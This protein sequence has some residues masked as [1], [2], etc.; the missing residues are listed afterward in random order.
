MFESIQTLPDVY[1]RKATLTLTGFCIKSGPF[2]KCYDQGTIWCQ[3]KIRDAAPSFPRSFL[4]SISFSTHI[5]GL[6]GG[7]DVCASRRID[8]AVKLHYE[9][10]S[11]VRQRPPLTAEQVRTLERVVINADK[12]VYDRIM[13]GYLLMLVYGRLRFSD[14]Q[15]I[16]GM[17]LESVHVES[18]VGWFP[19]VCC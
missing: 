14:G 19:G 9:K 8:G 5:L 13:S 4:L 6:L 15:R 2:A 1:L 10:R 16:T 17:R 3:Y 7:S 12:S 11:K 18:E